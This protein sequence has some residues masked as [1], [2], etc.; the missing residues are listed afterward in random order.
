MSCTE[1]ERKEAMLQRGER[2]T[3]EGKRDETENSRG[4]VGGAGDKDERNREAGKRS[5]LQKSGA[6][7]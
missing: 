3:R 5:G 6:N 4:Q 7:A 1:V 2:R